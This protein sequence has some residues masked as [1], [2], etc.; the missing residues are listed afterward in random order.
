LGCERVS[1]AAGELHDVRLEKTGSM[2]GG[3][4]MAIMKKVKDWWKID[5]KVLTCKIILLVL[6][7][8]PILKSI[9][10]VKEW[11]PDD[12]YALMLIAASF[13]LLL[14]IVMALLGEKFSD[15]QLV[16][17]NPAET[18][19]TNRLRKAKKVDIAFSSS[20]TLLPYIQDVL[21]KSK[22]DCR[23]LL[24]NAQAGNTRLKNKLLDYEERWKNLS[25]SNAQCKVQVR[26][27]NNTVFRLIILDEI[28]AYLGFYKFEENRLVGHNVPMLHV[29]IGTPVGEHLL[30]IAQNRFDAYWINGS[31]T[32]S[33]RPS[34]I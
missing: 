19:F 21:T 16:N 4:S 6:F 11:L 10:K 1:T 12:R 22:K 24:R 17:L 13:F 8:G 7:L 2:N 34:I 27:C 32:I 31:D 29:E 26:Y 30:K 25:L 15:V 18:K 14:Q 20:E 28:E 3:V 23:V 5:G 33:E 9:P